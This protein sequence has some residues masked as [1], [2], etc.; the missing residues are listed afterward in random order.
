MDMTQPQNTLEHR[1][2]DGWLGSPDVL[3]DPSDHVAIS[4][5]EM[6]AYRTFL[7]GLPQSCSCM[8]LQRDRMMMCMETYR[9]TS[10]STWEASAVYAALSGR[11]AVISV[12]QTLTLV[13]D[14]FRTIWGYLDPEDNDEPSQAQDLFKA[15]KAMIG[16]LEAAIP[17]T[18]ETKAWV[19]KRKTHIK[20]TGDIGVHMHC[21]I[22]HSVAPT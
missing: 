20:H 9:G 8:P 19:E 5:D 17:P 1:V 2:E 3:F 22:E 7:N 10:V 6:D 16:A 12:E 11:E 18:A 4:I 13:R 15:C 21:H 14:A